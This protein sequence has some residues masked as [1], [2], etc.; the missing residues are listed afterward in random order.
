[1]RSK[2]KQ[3]VRAPQRIDLLGPVLNQ[4]P[5]RRSRDKPHTVERVKRQYRK[6]STIATLADTNTAIFNAATH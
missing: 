5:S 1:M 6:C 3:T 4:Q 2:N